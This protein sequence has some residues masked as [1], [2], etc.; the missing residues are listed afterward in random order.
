[1]GKWVNCKVYTVDELK[2]KDLTEDDLHNIFDTGSLNISLVL[3]MFRLMG[4]KRKDWEIIKMAKTD[5]R[6]YDKYFIEDDQY[7]QLKK[8]LYEVFKNI[9]QYKDT[10]AESSRDWWLFQYC[11]RHNYKYK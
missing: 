1:M 3:H 9:Y 6:W 7:E 10:A 5:E 2:N 4:D 8:D 11:V